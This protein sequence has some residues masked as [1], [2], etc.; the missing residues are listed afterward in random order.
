N[1]QK[2]ITQTA[3]SQSH[4]LAFS[5]GSQNLSFYG[6]LGYINQEGI[7]KNTGRESF[8]ARILVNQRGFE[9]KLNVQLGINTMVTN[10]NFL[11]D[12]SSTSFSRLG[13]SFVFDG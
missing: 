12:Q 5:G 8:S 9:N 10:R 6:S 7:V 1:W 3:F 2:N 13:G 11:P 4:N